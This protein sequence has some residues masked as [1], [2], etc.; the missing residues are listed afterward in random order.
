MPLKKNHHTSKSN[1]L[2][3]SEPTLGKGEREL[4]LY[5]ILGH[6]QRRAKVI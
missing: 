1:T 3:S 5:D 2:L 4:G 6:R